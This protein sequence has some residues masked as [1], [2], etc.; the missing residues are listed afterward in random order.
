[1]NIY[2][3]QNYFEKNFKTFPTNNVKYKLLNLLLNLPKNIG[4]LCLGFVHSKLVPLLKRI[5]I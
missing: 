4:Y 1:M 5:N 2:K 3:N